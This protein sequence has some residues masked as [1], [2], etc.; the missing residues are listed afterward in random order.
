MHTIMNAN[1]FGVFREYFIIPSHNPHNPD[2][3]ADIPIITTTPQSQPIGSSLVAVSPNT[4]PWLNLLANSTNRSEDLLLAWMATSSGNTPAGMNN[5]VHNVI[6]Y[7]DFN[8]S[9]LKDFNA[10]TVIR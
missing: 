1:S 6:A 3:F 7:P 10:V 9:D 5:L 2:T 8:P 4:G